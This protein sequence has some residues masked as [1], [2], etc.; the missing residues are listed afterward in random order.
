METVLRRKLRRNGYE[1]SGAGTRPSPRLLARYA[2]EALVRRSAMRKRWAEEAR[3][4]AAATHP[5]A[6]RLTSRQLELAGRE[7]YG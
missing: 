3:D 5:V 4:A 7:A 1:I 2:R 6:A